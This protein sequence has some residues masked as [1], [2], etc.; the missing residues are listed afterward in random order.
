MN[1]LVDVPRVAHQIK[2]IEFEKNV[3]FENSTNFSF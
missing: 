1:K 3:I 2:K